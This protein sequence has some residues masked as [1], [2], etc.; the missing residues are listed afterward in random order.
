MIL[1]V[2]ATRRE[3]ATLGALA[4]GTGERAA[5]AL[6]SLLEKQRPALVLIVG[7]CGGLDPSL[8]AGDLVLAW[9]VLRLGMAELAPPAPIVVAA[10]EALRAARTAFVRSTL[11][12]LDR[13]AAT[14]DEKRALWNE[15]GAAGVDMETHHLAA[16]AVEA[17]IPWLALRAIVDPADRSLPA[18]L[19]GW[20]D[21]ADEA[22]ALATATRRPW[23]WPAYLRLALGWQRA[24]RSLRQATAPDGPL[25]RALVD[26]LS[27]AAVAA[28][29]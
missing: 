8:R 9:R 10:H 14:R 23:E 11:L 4:L 13:P 22:A 27:N 15:H 19:R 17:E 26:A 5:H 28:R 20:R 1:R 3:G 25:L 7:V 29:R 2:T 6:R 12:T 24:V 16:I 21:D 18:S